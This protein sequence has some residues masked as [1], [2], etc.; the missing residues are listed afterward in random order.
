MESLPTTIFAV[1]DGIE[2]SWC[3][4]ARPAFASE[5]SSSADRGCPAAIIPGRYGASAGASSAAGGADGVRGDLRGFSRSTDVRRDRGQPRWPAP[6]ESGTVP[7]PRE[8][9]CRFTGAHGDR[10]GGETVQGSPNV[11]AAQRMHVENGCA[12]SRLRL[13]AR[14][15]A[16]F[17]LFLRRARHGER[18]TPAHSM[19]RAPQ[20]RDREIVG[21][22]SVRTPRPCRSRAAQ[23]VLQ[24]A[25]RSLFGREQA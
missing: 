15:K 8:R 11:R 12:R 24:V 2:K 7:W 19:S 3:D 22:L 23:N 10:R 4:I 18:T 9:G 16:F 13:R 1:A 25:A 17:L 6:S 20:A 5:T 21:P 14:D